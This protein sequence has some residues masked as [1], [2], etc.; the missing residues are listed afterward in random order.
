M[1]SDATPSNDS[2]P[3]P[4]TLFALLSDETRVAILREL[5]DASGAVAFADLCSRAGIQDTGRFNYHLG[6]LRGHL[7]EKTTNGYVLTTA[8][9][10]VV[11]TTDPVNPLAR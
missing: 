7:V 11:T 1:H 10:H 9:E 6:E 4:S 5:D 2:A 8:G 3:D